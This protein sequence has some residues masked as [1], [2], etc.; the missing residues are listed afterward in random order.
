MFWF[1]IGVY[2]FMDMVFYAV[3]GLHLYHLFYGPGRYF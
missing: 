3:G 2:I 1:E